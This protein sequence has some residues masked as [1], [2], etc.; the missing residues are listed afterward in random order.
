MIESAVVRL[1]H[2]AAAAD[3]K[4]RSVE[5]TTLSSDRSSITL[6]VRM[7]LSQK[8]VDTWEVE[9]RNCPTHAIECDFKPTEE[10]AD[11]DLECG[12]QDNQNWMY[13]RK[14]EAE[15]PSHGIQTLVVEDELQWD[16]GHSARV[17]KTALQRV[18][19][20]HADF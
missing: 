2:D 15:M 14:A 11:L 12:K 5:R 13:V 1:N 20:S 6:E 10:L 18:P 9:N 17:V 8:T 4:Q 3:F 7:E 19:D 16:P